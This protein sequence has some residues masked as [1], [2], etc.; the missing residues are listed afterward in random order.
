MEESARMEQTMVPIYAYYLR[1][2]ISNRRCDKDR[3]TRQRHKKS[4]AERCCQS[5]LAVIKIF[6]A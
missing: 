1:Q 3:H 6:N 2:E 4:A 5:H